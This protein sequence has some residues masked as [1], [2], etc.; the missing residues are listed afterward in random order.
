V[1]D[2]EYLLKLTNTKHSE[3]GIPVLTWVHC[4][5]LYNCHHCWDSRANYWCLCVLKKL[6]KHCIRETLKILF[7]ICC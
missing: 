4:N 3:G 1:F 7:W 6:V 5:M 2:A